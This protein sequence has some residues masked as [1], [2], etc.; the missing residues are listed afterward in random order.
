MTWV[1]SWR[2][3]VTPTRGSSRLTSTSTPRAR[4]AAR[5]QGRSWR[6]A[7]QSREGPRRHANQGADPPVHG[8]PALKDRPELMERIVAMRSANMT[9][10]QIADQ[11]NAEGIPTLRGGTQWR[12]SSIQAALGYKRPGPQDRLPALDNRGGNGGNGHVRGSD[13]IGDMPAA[14]VRGRGGRSRTAAAR[15]GGTGAN[16]TSGGPGCT[17]DVP[18]QRV[19]GR[20]GRSRTRSCTSWGGMGANR[21]S[22]GPVARGRARAAGARSWGRSRTRS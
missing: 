12:P 5:S 4:S 19:R 6:S 2:G 14:R 8:R 18:E 1:C 21:T 17:G 15:G 22:G 10:W 3:S 11:L 16:R 9:L 20:G 7:T 13:C